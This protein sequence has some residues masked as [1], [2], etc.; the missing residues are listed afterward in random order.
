VVFDALTLE[1]V[2]QFA[3]I[4]EAIYGTLQGVDVVQGDQEALPWRRR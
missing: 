1:H 2:R 3:E 4:G